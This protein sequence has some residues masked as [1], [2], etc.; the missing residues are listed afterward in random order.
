[1]RKSIPISQKHGV[2]PTMPVCFFCGEPTGEIA[3]LGKLKGDVE[4][5]KHMILSYEPCDKCKKAFSQG[6]LI[7][8]V[9]NTPVIKGQIPIQNEPAL[10][11]T[12]SY[13]LATEDFINRSFE[14]EMAKHVITFGKCLME[15]DE[16]A[17][18]QKQYEKV[19]EGE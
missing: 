1:M 4:A 12:G 7:I 10:Y 5:P 9:K 8:G 17:Y 3:L 13:V 15:D 14:P 16:L 11:P 6:I 18:L 19:C 2:N